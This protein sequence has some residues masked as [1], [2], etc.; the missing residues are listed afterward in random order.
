MV[1]RLLVEQIVPAIRLK[2]LRLGV[3]QL[4]SDKEIL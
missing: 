4:K 1:E 2:P 3:V